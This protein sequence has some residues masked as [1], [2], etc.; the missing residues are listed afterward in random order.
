M[1]KT[2]KQEDHKPM[3]V[4][5]PTREQTKNSQNTRPIKA[6]DPAKNIEVVEWVIKSDGNTP[7][8]VRVHSP[9]MLVN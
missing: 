6:K 2:G 4:R 9:S 3:I 1:G 8:E 5:Q 7:N